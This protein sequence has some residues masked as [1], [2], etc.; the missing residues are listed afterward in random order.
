M[1][2]TLASV[3][4]EKMGRAEGFS[5]LNRASVLGLGGRKGEL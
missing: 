4:R 2:T 3:K 1:E 5:R